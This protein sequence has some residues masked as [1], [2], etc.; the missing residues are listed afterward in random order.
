MLDVWRKCSVHTEIESGEDDLLVT[1]V[2]N[3]ATGEA[4]VP[5]AEQQSIQAE[6]LGEEGSGACNADCPVAE[7][8]SNQAEHVGEEGT[9]QPGT[10]DGCVV[11]H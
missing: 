1:G 11:A 5:V 9:A 7:Q 4:G 2:G 6:H 8:Q 10:R 3:S